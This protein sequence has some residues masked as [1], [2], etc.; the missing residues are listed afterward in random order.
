M[1]HVKTL[2]VNSNIASNTF[3]ASVVPISHVKAPTLQTIVTTNSTQEISR[4]LTK[5]KHKGFVT[6]LHRV[7]KKIYELIN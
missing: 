4:C 6:T 7:L 1:L 5:E 2:P 3:N